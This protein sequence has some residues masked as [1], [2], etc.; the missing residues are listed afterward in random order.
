M[1]RNNCLL[2]KLEVATYC[3]AEELQGVK[4][5]QKCENCNQWMNYETLTV[6]H[7]KKTAHENS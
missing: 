4:N 7:Q 1:S 5:V 2:Y 6:Y 3:L